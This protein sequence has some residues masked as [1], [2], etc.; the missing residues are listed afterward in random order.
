MN[1]HNFSRHRSG[2][3]GMCCFNSDGDGGAG[4]GTGAGDGDDKNKQQGN[5]DGKEKDKDAKFTQEDVNKILTE[6][7]AEEKAKKEKELADLKAEL[8]RKAEL[9]KMSEADRTKARL[10]DIEK[11]YQEELDKNALNIQKDETR[12]L[13]ETEKLPTSFLDFVLVPKDDT[14]TKLNVSELKK[15]FEEE[16]KKAVEAKVPSHKPNFGGG[17]NN[18]NNDGRISGPTSGL[19]NLQNSIAEHYN[20]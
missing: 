8:E 14:K 12:K 9:D 5:E 19:F 11:K 10:E 4:G 13:L 20:K 18:N 3:L 6:R 17:N 1:L 7:L 2:R 16:V 15:V